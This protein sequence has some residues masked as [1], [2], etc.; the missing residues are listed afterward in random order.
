MNELP[1]RLRWRLV[2]PSL[3]IMLAALALI[4][5]A[6]A[7]YPVIYR[8]L[9]RLPFD[10]FFSTTIQF[11]STTC[12]VAI[13][14]VIWLLDPARR[15]TL[16]VFG[17]ALAMGGIV[18]ETVK[19]VTGRARPEF[20]VAME[21]KEALRVQQYINEH[22]GTPVRCDRRDQWLLFQPNRSYFDSEYASFPSGHANTAFALAACLCIVYGRGRIV[23]FVLA[24]GC[25]LARVWGRRHFHE[26]VL[27]GGALGWIIAQWVFS[28]NWPNTLAGWLNQ[29]TK[30][31]P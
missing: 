27:F 25:A 20:S 19:Q 3:V 9:R 11:V 26:D 17:A 5:W 2:W 10:E 22:P 29:R 28:W 21:R 18:N 12:V 6:D 8:F 23:W 14:A 16:I 13:F 15:R 1:R 7:L 30:L 24:A 31:F 4:P